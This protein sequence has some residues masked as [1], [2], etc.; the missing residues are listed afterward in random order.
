M[1]PRRCDLVI[2]LVTMAIARTPDEACW[3]STT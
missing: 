3:T 2:H 1:M